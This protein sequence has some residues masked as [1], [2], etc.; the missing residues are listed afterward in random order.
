MKSFLQ[1][2][3]TGI[4]DDPFT[5]NLHSAVEDAKFHKRW[6]QEYMTLLENYKKEREEGRAEGRAEGREEGIFETLASLVQKKLLAL[7]DAA[8]Q[9]GISEEEFLKK[10]DLK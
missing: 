9:A 8:E 5:D 4:P 3:I 6:R 7:K 1:F 10:T 2:L